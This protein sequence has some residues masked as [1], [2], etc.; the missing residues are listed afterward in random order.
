MKFCSYEDLRAIAPYRCQNFD[1]S[2]F[3]NIIII[4]DDDRDS[5]IYTFVRGLPSDIRARLVAVGEHEG[6]LNLLWTS[7]IPPGWGPWEDPVDRRVV[8][9]GMDDS[10]GVTVE[11]DYWSIAESRVASSPTVIRA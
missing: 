11:G 1:V 10:G 5:R 3:Q 9:D 6:S 2:V 7:P 8:G 4:W